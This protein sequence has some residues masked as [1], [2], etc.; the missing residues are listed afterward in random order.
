MVCLKESAMNSGIIKQYVKYSEKFW[1]GRPDSQ[2]GR[3]VCS[4][5][6]CVLREMYFVRGFAN[7]KLENSVRGFTTCFENP[8]GHHVQYFLQQ[9]FMSWTILKFFFVSNFH[10]MNFTFTEIFC[11][12]YRFLLTSEVKKLN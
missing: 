5:C 11:C 7:F 1:Q 10:N 9:I 12:Q 3:T 8:N 6:D 2:R 4:H